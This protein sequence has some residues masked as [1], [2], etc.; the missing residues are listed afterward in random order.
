M[1]DTAIVITWGTSFPGR[2]APSLALFMEVTQ[3]WEGKRAAG[4]VS[5]FRSYMATTGSLSKHGGFML[6]EGDAA[7]LD[8]VCASEEFRTLMVKGIHLLSGIEVNRFD[9]GPAI[10]KAV[11]RVLGVRKQLG[12]G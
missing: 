10:G 5:D 8:R 1:A 3:W 12:I 7:K 4:E 11:E 6:V 2:E 9:T